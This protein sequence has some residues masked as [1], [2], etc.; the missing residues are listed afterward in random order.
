MKSERDQ[1]LVE[2]EKERKETISR[3]VRERSL[4]DHTNSF[5]LIL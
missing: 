3:E 5:D 2:E 1:F 4:N